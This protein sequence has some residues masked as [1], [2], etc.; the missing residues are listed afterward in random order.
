MNMIWLGPKCTKPFKCLTRVQHEGRLLGKPNRPSKSRHIASWVC[1]R[2]MLHTM[3]TIIVPSLIASHDIHFV[4]DSVCCCWKRL[5]LCRE[6]K[7][8]PPIMFSNFNTLNIVFSVVW[9][10][11]V[12]ITFLCLTL[13]MISLWTLSSQLTFGSSCPIIETKSGMLCI[14]TWSVMNIAIEDWNLDGKCS[15]L[16]EFIMPKYFTRNDKYCQVYI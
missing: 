8:I 13:C 2:S 11:V 7:L 6:K 15:Q 10:L 1:V 16:C 14:L 5:L 3:T 9:Y 12:A 4:C